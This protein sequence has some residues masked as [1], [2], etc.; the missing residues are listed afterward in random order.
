MASIYNSF[1]NLCTAMISFL[2]SLLGPCALSDF[3]FNV[4][5]TVDIFQ[6][7]IHWILPHPNQK[8]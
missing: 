4:S 3:K 6:T 7:L 2:F 5:L 8:L 1:T